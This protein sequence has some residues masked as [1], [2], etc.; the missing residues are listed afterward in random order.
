MLYHAE[1]EIEVLATPSLFFDL[2]WDFER[3]PEFVS[4]VAG[5]RVLSREP[6]EVHVEITARLLWIPF[7]YELAVSR[8]D[9]RAVRWQRVAG[10]FARAEGAWTLV[11]AREG[12]SRIRYENAVDP[13]I[14]APGF[15]V[16]HVLEQSLPK[17][18]K[19]FRARAETLARER[20]S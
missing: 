15:V 17:L 20:E 14:P 6:G 9:D 5:V 1:R 16:Q 7:R 18:M 4:D 2:V 10:A 11:E 13:G 19:E 8:E 12:R 3:Y